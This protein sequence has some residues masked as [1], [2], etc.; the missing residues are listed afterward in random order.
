MTL[1]RPFRM[2]ATETTLAQYR[3][4]ASAAGKAMPVQ[5]A[6]N[7][8]VRQPVVNVTW[9]QAAHFCAAAG[10]R[11]PTEAEWEWAALGGRVNSVYPW[12]DS[13]DRLGANAGFPGRDGWDTAAPVGTF[14][15]N[16]YGL[17][18]MAGNV[19]EWTADWFDAD[20]YRGSPEDDPKGPATGTERVT[21]GGSWMCAENFCKNMRPAARNHATPDTGLNN[22]GFRC[23]R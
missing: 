9:D 16:G 3:D 4:Y 7:T 10:G 17:V 21:R 22:L 8:D 1:S 20:Y 2:A 12:G 19:W 18:D 11:L 15:P 5:P 23:A 6:W 13:Y 14:P